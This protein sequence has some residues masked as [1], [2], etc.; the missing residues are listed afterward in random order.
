MRVALLA[1]VDTW[2]LDRTR[3][4]DTDVKFMFL[5]KKKIIHIYYEGFV[6]APFHYSLINTH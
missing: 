2:S 1:A 5:K 4:R 3:T 6:I